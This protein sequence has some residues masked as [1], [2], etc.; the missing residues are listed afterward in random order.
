MK[1]VV[2]TVALC[3]VASVSFAQKKVVKEALNLAKNS[4]KPN[5][6]EARGLI[7]SALENAETKDQAN[8]WYVAG[9]IEDQ[10]FN[11][12]KMKQVLG[13]KPNEAAMY[14]SLLNELPFFLKCYDL[15]HMPDKKG[16]IKPK[17]LKNT[18]NI[19]EANLVYYINA[20]A[21]YFD[22]QDYKGAYKSFSQYLEI[23]DHKMFV[24]T[25]VAK[26]DSNFMTVQ[27]YAAVAAIQMKD[28]S[29]SIPALEKAK[30]TDF[31]RNDVY[32][33]LCYEY[34]QEKDTV[35]FEKTLEEGMKIFPKENY[36]LLNLINNYV[37]SNRNEKAVEYLNKAISE[38]ANNP[39]YY[40]VL[41]YVYEKGMNDFVKAEENYN[42][43]LSID[44]NYLEALSNLGR[45]YYNQG[46]QKQSDANMINDAKKYQEELTVA[47]E[48]F[49]K[50]LPY[51]EKAHSLKAD[52]ME[53]MI[54]LR[55]IYYNL[56]MGDKLKEIEAK[57]N[58]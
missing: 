14:E 11:A 52:E 30:A 38:D 42:K 36:Y 47:K 49:K 1:Q 3:L 18:R 51:F 9:F 28:R 34:Q 4:K 29:L 46:V 45:I 17:N 12:E 20:G 21:F 54:A 23:V 16:K 35:M 50:A 8:T 43:A 41:G 2:L 33:Y 7:K 22:K 31:R 15:D 48:L 13:Q 56:D 10:A 39:Q 6:T 26:R 55:G 40:S 24:D 25:D 27:F 19:L 44:A 57:M 37:F 32:Q 53:Y 58:V 5:F